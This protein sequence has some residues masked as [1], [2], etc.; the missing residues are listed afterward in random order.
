MQAA[1]SASRRSRSRSTRAP[2]WPAA[3]GR[4]ASPAA[5]TASRYAA[6]GV[7]AELRQHEPGQH[8]AR[9]RRGRAPASG[10]ARRCAPG[11]RSSAPARRCGP[12]RAAG[13]TTLRSAR[14][15]LAVGDGVLEADD[16]AQ[17]ARARRAGRCRRPGA[18]AIAGQ[19]SVA[20]SA[21]PSVA[22]SSSIPN[23]SG[24]RRNSRSRSAASQKVEVA[25]IAGM[26]RMLACR[27]VRSRSL[28]RSAHDPDEH[29]Q[30]HRPVRATTCAPRCAGPAVPASRTWTHRPCLLDEDG[31]VGSDADFV[32]YNQPQH[33]S[34][35]VRMA[36]KTPPPQA[37]DSVD[38]DLAR[39]PADTTGSCWPPRPTAARSGRC[40][41][42]RWCSPTWRPA[43]RRRR[44]RCRPARR[45]RFVGARDLPPQRR[46]EVPRRRAGLL[47]RARRAGRRLRHR[48]RARRVGRLVRAG[49][50]RRRHRL[51]AC[52]PE[53]PPPPRRPPRRCRRPPPRLPR[54]PSRRPRRRRAGAARSPSCASARAACGCFRAPPLA[55]AAGRPRPGRRVRPPPHRCR[56]RAAARATR[57]PSRSPHPRPTRRRRVPAAT[58]TRRPARTA[59]L[60]ADARQ[61]Q[62]ATAAGAAGSHAGSAQA[63]ARPCRLRRRRPR[64]H[65]GPAQPP[66]APP[67][68]AES[69]CSKNQK[70]ELTALRPGPADPLVFSLG[71]QPAEGHGD[72]D[73][74]ASV[75]AFDATGEKLAIVWYMHLNEFFGGA[76]T[77]RRQPHGRLRRRRA[78]PRR[79]RPDARQRQLADLHDQL[80]SAA[81]VHR[82]R[83]RV[84]ARCRTSTTARNWSAST[85]PT[86]SRA[87]RC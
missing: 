7:L 74:D 49:E 73:M 22:A 17:H 6:A 40:R 8:A 85:W 18:A 30:Q 10:S 1:A 43:R 77:H 41:T 20:P 2:A 62:S 46:L 48:H 15:E 23:G 42:C 65:A 80:R 69:T 63:P 44:S 61:P 81:D 72:V 58:S 59:L 16:H 83:Q 37:S 26:V 86:P 84:S 64:R 33:Y 27:C 5:T 56:Y 29:G 55:P 3:A 76:A 21:I 11:R 4:S 28:A 75:I 14:G 52:A 9:R 39:V 50:P 36:G 45:P 51:A 13:S 54:T 57:C 31:E 66:A 82:H 32:F 87:P 25:R 78:D 47:L 34:G 19:Y 68:A 79:P 24:A 12:A 71:W 35:A 53:P 70:L 38:V 60:H 67:P